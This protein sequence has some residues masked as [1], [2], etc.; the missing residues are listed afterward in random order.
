[1]A[2]VAAIRLLVAAAT[3]VVASPVVAP[4]AAQIQ[5]FTG[6]YLDTTEPP[7]RQPILTDMCHSLSCGLQLHSLREN[8][9]YRSSEAGY[10]D[11]DNLADPL[12]D[13]IAACFL[14]GYF[15]IYDPRHYFHY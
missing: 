3:L 15:G 2:T 8:Y 13:N 10:F 5:K 14:T 1:M 4:R 11:S 6:A 12:F 7:F 9:G